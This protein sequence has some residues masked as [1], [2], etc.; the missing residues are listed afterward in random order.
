MYTS[1]STGA[2][3]P[4]CVRTAAPVSGSN[5][6]NKHRGTHKDFASHHQAEPGILPRTRS[7]VGRTIT[8]CSAGPANSLIKRHANLRPSTQ[9]ASALPSAANA[10]A[11]PQNLAPASELMTVPGGEGRAVELKAG[12]YFKVINTHGEQVSVFLA[13]PATPCKS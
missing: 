10:A 9:T 4:F 7:D 1:V 5:A 8:S 6:A 11:V 3:L 13:G 12:Q 2:Q